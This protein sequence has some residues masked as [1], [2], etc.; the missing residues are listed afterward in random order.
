MFSLASLLALLASA[1]V[2]GA[3]PV[4]TAPS[5]QSTSTVKL[6]TLAQAQGK[7]YFG[8]AID[9]NDLVNATYLSIFN[10]KTL[11]GQTTP[12]NSMKWVRIQRSSESHLLMHA[13]TTHRT[14][15]NRLAESS[16][17]ELPRPLPTLP[18]VMVNYCEVW[19]THDIPLPS[20]SMVLQGTIAFG[21]I[22]FHHGSRAATSMRPRW[23]PSCRR[24]AAR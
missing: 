22:S 12:T 8:S 10:D 14:R 21:T 3:S 16:L 11:F 20:G 23:L 15:R 24:T 13:R 1:T 2:I 6:N 19:I 5:T 9:N 7:V 17:L 4:A 18:R